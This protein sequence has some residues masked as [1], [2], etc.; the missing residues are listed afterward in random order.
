MAMYAAFLRGI[1]VGGHGAT[2]E[3]LIRAFERLGFERVSTFRASGNVLFDS[4]GSTTPEAEPIERELASELGYEA[5]VFLRSADEVAAAAA[6]EPFTA[7][8]LTASNG[9]LQVSFLRTSPTPAAAAEAL[10]LATEADPLALRGLELYW[11]PRGSMRDS[12][13]DLKALDRVLG[14]S[15]MRTMGTVEQMARRLSGGD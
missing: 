10:A 2:K 13:L 8:Q 9:K 14:V 12:E 6:F 5:P 15:T 4:G 11:L 3:Q 7:R 1:N